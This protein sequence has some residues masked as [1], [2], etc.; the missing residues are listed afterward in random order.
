MKRPAPN[1]R[2]Y[3]TRLPGE[4]GK[5]ETAREAAQLTKQHQ[6]DHMPWMNGSQ[7]QGIVSP[8]DLLEDELALGD[9]FAVAC[10]SS[11]CN[12][13]VLTASPD[14][15]VVVGIG[16]VMGMVATTNAL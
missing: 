12:Q 8:L 16:I 14:N 3:M 11:I 1:V 2:E 15:A 9:K 4:P 10:P 13:D 7:E 6:I 5:Y